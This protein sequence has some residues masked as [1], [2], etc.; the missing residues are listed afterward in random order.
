MQGMT[1]Y[2]IILFLG[3]AT[4]IFYVLSM[5]EKP[6]LAYMYK[7]K[8]FPNALLMRQI[9]GQLKRLIT[10]LPP[11]MVISMLASAGLIIYQYINLKTTLTFILLVVFGIQLIRLVILLKPR[12]DGVKGIDS[13]EEYTVLNRGV[14]KLAQLHHE[15]LFMTV[16]SFFIQ[17]WVVMS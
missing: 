9:H 15:G 6:I 2:L 4:G 16:V 3:Y 1:P 13:D 8:L 10:L 17:L 7:S 14:I 12:I 5:I 11:T